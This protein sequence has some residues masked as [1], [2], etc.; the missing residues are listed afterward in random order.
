MNPD[1]PYTEF[2]K[3]L[4]SFLPTS[5]AAKR[6]IWATTIIE[7]DIDIKELSNLLEAEPKIAT[8]F[9]WLLS[10]IGTYDSNTL[11]TALPFLLDLSDRLNPAYKQSF[12]SF[13]HIVGVPPENEGRAIDLLFQLLMTGDI[14]TTTKSRAIW[15]LFELTKKYPELKNELKLCLA[16]QQ[17]KYSVDFDKRVTKILRAMEQ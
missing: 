15:V 9:L 13:W 4:G 10:E 8:R 1:F 17:G 14:N 11:L 5:S 12:A 3:E 16:D 2:Y 7:N 6:R